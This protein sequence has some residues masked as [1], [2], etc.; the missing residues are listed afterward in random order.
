MTIQV[1]GKQDCGKCE[2]AKKMISH[3][4]QKYGNGQPVEVAFVDMDT[5]DGLAE[6]AFRDVLHI[7]TTIVQRDGQDLARWDGVV[8]DTEQL[9]AQFL[10]R[11]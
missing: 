1:F 3:F 8:P 6:G 10:G 5:V 2:S 11:A 9:K 4:A 7:P